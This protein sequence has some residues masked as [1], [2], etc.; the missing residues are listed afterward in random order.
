MNYSEARPSIQS[1]DILAWSHYDW[2]SWYD[3]QVQGVR[4]GTESEYCHVA[5]ARVMD[6]R[7]WC[8][9]SVE[10]LV[11]CVPLSNLIEHGF[12]WIPMGRQMSEVELEFAYSKVAIARYSKLEAIKA[13]M[14]AALQSHDD[15]V[16]ECAKYVRACCSRSGLEVGMRDTPAAVVRGAQDMGCPVYFV[17]PDAPAGAAA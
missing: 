17:Q 12:Y 6:G 16:M 7:V 1:G 3:L 9:E 8:L 2:S 14:S 4:I 5:L 15:N 10:P 13:Q 11:R